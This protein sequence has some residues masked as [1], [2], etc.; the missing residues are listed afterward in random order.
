MAEQISARDA[1]RQDAAPLAA[2]LNAIIARGGTTALEVPFDVEPF[3][4][5]YMERD[6]QLL[7]SVALLDDRTPVG[8]Q[9]LGR[10]PKLPGDWADIATF[11]QPEPKIRGVG[12]A[13]WAHTLQR[14]AGLGV[15]TINATIRADNREGLSYYG[16]L[17]FQDYKVDRAIPLRDG[18]PVDRISK[19][20]DLSAMQ[21]AP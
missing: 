21:G 17:G 18:T 8:F 19:R 11:A 6:S 15:A 9:Y 3:R 4:A 14:A 12:R 16:A 13:L 5:A 20:L 2:I 1:T 7:C 10:H